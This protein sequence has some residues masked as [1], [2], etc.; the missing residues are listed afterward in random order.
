MFL[1]CFAPFEGPTLKKTSY[2]ANKNM[3][4]TFPFQ[5][6]WYHVA[7]Y[8]MSS[9]TNRLASSCFGISWNISIWSRKDVVMMYL[10]IKFQ[11]HQVLGGQP[12]TSHQF[13]KCDNHPLTFSLPNKSFF[14]Q[15]RNLIDN[16]NG[17][18]VP[19]LIVSKKTRLVVTI[20]H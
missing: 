17:Q 3:Y 13:A 12:P 6:L 2:T 1:K 11:K 16:I 9:W 18:L 15:I 20:R 10:T 7:S 19:E 4:I 8:L 5:N 14:F